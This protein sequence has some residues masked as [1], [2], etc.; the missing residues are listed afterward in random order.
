MHPSASLTRPGERLPSFVFW[1]LTIAGTILLYWLCLRFLDPGYFAPLSPYHIDF[2]DYAAMRFKTATA[3]LLNYPRPVAFLSMKVVGYGGLGGSMAGAIAIALVNLLLTV[4]YVRRQF[5][6]YSRWLLPSVLIYLALNIAHPQFYTEH[7]HDLPAQV[8]YLFLFLGLLAWQAWM[9]RGRGKILLVVA[10]ISIVAFAFA[11]E[12]YF[13]SAL[14]LLIGSA[15]VDGTSNRRRYIWFVAFVLA[16]EFASL[17][18]TR[19]INSPFVDVEA[20]ANS[21]YRINLS[22]GSIATTFLFYAYHLLA[23][24]L[25]LAIIGGLWIASHERRDFIQALAYPA[26]AFGALAPHALLPNHRF[27]EYAWAGAPLLLVPVLFVGARAASKRMQFGVLSVCAGLALA[28]PNG[29]LSRYNTDDKR[30][31]QHQEKFNGAVLASFDRLRALPDSARVLVTGLESSVVPWQVPEFIEAAFGNKISWTIVVPPGVHHRNNSVRAVFADASTVRVND[32]DH[33]V[34]YRASGELAEL[35]KMEKAS[36]PAELP[37]TYIPQIVMQE[38]LA[39]RR[40]DDPRGWLDC[41]ET[42]L[43]W[44]FPADAARYLAR[45]KQAGGERAKDYDVLVARAM[46]ISANQQRARTIPAKLFAT[47]ANIVE[48]DEYG[49]GVTELSWEIPDGLVVEL[50]VDAPDG[51]ML[52]GSS[53]SGRAKTD[54]WVRDGMEF[55]LQDVTGGKPLTRE[56]TLATVKVHVTR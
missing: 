17:L 1:T 21:T 22:P 12:T 19:H 15:I 51:P 36:A 25:V 37:A 56:N 24:G 14:C 33:V 16:V 52:T 13:L 50:R 45:A 4:L 2:Y 11:K 55:F 27:E 34:M 6:L 7:R 38:E 44:G 43:N 53:K 9:R 28:G 23:P 35:K 30:Y 8:S 18:W 32:H 46:Q 26:A 48:A 10:A 31:V 54:R 3:L 5:G 47:P 29:Y 40:P 20:A 41:A 49:L 42:A 39:R